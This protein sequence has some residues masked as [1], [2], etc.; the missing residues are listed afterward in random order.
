MGDVQPEPVKADQAVSK[1]N[2]YRVSQKGEGLTQ[3]K[4]P[5]R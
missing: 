1:L 3:A 4:P 5:L 2:K